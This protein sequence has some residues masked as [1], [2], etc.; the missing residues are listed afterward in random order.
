ML[1]YQKIIKPKSKV[2]RTKSTLEKAVKFV[3]NCKFIFSF[4]KN[5][6]QKNIFPILFCLIPALTSAQSGSCKAKIE[7]EKNR[8]YSSA[9]KDGA[10]F[11]LVLTN[12][13]NSSDVY[14]LSAL[15]INGNC[16]NND[17]SSTSENVNLMG[18][19]LDNNNAPITSLTVSS[20]QTASFSI[21]LIVPQGTPFN[22]WNCTQINATSTNC[23]SY[24]VNTV[25]HTIVNN[26]SEN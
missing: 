25:V 16:D 24:T 20:H 7:V 19:F 1:K 26:P 9:G 23:T 8:I 22:K 18:S 6:F 10:Y 15:N 3:T 5:I 2:M 4:K 12:D 13:G 17:Q 11:T 14:N 21:H